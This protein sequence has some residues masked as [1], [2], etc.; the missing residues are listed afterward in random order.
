[1]NSIIKIQINN[2]E[3]IIP[4]DFQ[5]LSNKFTEGLHLSID[6]ETFNKIVEYGNFYLSLTDEMQKLLLT[7]QIIFEKQSEIQNSEN[8]SESI[9]SIIHNL[10]L[11]KLLDLLDHAS[12]LEITSLVEICAYEIAKIIKGKTTDEIR[13]L[14]NI[15]D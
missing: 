1:M 14:F 11:T 4:E 13:I 12:K 2:L 6:T 15:N 9:K 8:L 7:P 5:K 3:V 10:D